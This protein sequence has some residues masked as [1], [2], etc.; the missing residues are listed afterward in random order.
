MAVDGIDG[1]WIG[2]SDLALSLNIEFE[3]KEH[4]DAIIRIFEGCNKSGKIP[5]ICCFNIG[6]TKKWLSKGALFITSGADATFLAQ[7]SSNT[8]KE[9]GR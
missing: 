8:L 1:C 2:P 9:L 5:G 3:G 7:G 6:M 4:D